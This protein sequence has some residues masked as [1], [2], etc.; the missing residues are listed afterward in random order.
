MKTRQLI[1][2]TL[3]FLYLSTLEIT[4]AAFFSPLIL[5]YHPQFKVDKFFFILKWHYIQDKLELMCLMLQRN[6]L[7]RC[8]THSMHRQ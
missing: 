5:Y 3:K 7:N 2:Y 6:D 1:F 4:E 8:L